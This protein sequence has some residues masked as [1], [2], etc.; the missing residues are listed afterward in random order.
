VDCIQDRLLLLLE[1]LQIDDD[2][3]PAMHQT[4]S[5]QT[6]LSE[7]V[8]QSS[9]SSSLPDEKVAMAGKPKNLRAASSRSNTSPLK[10]M[11]ISGS[12]AHILGL[13]ERNCAQLHRALC[14]TSQDHAMGTLATREAAVAVAVNDGGAAGAA[15]SGGGMLFHR[16]IVPYILTSNSG[17]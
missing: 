14:V 16:K 6:W 3:A 10:N 2:L 17:M 5:S 15:C 8:Q 13:R 11:H 12:A 9:D 4:A 7:I 1:L